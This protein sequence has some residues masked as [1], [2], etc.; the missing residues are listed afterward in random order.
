MA[1]LL[2]DAELGGIRRKADRYGYVPDFDSV[3]DLLDHIEVLQAE[4]AAMRQALEAVAWLWPAF[5]RC[6]ACYH[7]RD[8]GHSDSC[9]TNAAL[10]GT[11]GQALLD[12]LKRLRA[13]VAPAFGLGED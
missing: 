6:T 3:D 13:G 8:D 12:E 4:A 2:T 10:S 7:T 1:K 11:A 5:K 9:T